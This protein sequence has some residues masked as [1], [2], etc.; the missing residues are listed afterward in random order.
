MDE[1]DGGIMKTQRSG[2]ADTFSDQDYKDA[3]NV[4]KNY[5]RRYTQWCI[6]CKK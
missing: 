4:D 6:L 3:S 1:I 5:V 2:F